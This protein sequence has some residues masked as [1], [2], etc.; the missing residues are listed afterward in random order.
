MK[1][2]QLTL[3]KPPFVVLFCFSISLQRNTNNVWP[4]C[5]I[6]KDDGRTVLVSSRVRER[7]SKVGI[8]VDAIC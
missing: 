2:V 4:R 8:L 6:R 5:M 7:K 3:F 1:D